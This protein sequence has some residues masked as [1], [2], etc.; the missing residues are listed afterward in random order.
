M[1]QKPSETVDYFSLARDCASPSATMPFTRNP[2]K[3]FMTSHSS[4]AANMSQQ[5]YPKMSPRKN[6]YSAMYSFK[7]MAARSSLSMCDPSADLVICQG[8]WNNLEWNHSI[9]L[10]STK[11]E[12][13]RMEKTQNGKTQNGKTQ[14]G[15]TQN[16]KTQK[17]IWPQLESLR[18]EK[19][20]K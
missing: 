6:I 12:S 13:L 16:G 18:K 8:A 10:F 1:P 17:D 20:Q 15:K 7:T 11:L 14:N 19:T 9:N 2:A 3:L 4:V 5:I